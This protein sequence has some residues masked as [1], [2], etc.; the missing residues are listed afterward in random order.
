M[1]SVADKYQSPDKYPSE[2]EAILLSM[3][4]NSQDAIPNSQIL[5]LRFEPRTESSD[6]GWLF[7]N[8]S[9]LS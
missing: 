6:G 2:N 4:P 9:N 7:T 3:I 5:Y 8:S 1:T